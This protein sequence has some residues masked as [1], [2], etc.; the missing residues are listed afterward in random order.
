[1]QHGRNDDIA[2]GALQHLGKRDDEVDIDLAHPLGQAPG[3]GRDDHLVEFHHHHLLAVFQ[4]D[5]RY[6][7]LGR[8]S[9]GMSDLDVLRRSLLAPGFMAHDFR[10]M[11]ERCP[12]M[13]SLQGT[14]YRAT[15]HKQAEDRYR[16]IVFHNGSYISRH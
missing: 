1:M 14:G 8:P 2:A 3:T 13:T 6:E 11:S 15:A 9:V 4:C 16:Q 7:E 12:G 10:S 5:S